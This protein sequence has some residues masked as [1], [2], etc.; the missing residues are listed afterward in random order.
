VNIVSINL[1]PVQDKKAYYKSDDKFWNK[2][3]LSFEGFESKEKGKLNFAMKN[4]KY[5]TPV[6][7]KIKNK[8]KSL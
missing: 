5:F 7:K 8:I 6:S 2:T 3:N 1:A 4:E